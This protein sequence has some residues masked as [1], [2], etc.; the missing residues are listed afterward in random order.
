MH[1][2]ERHPSIKYFVIPKSLKIL[3]RVV[4]LI[5]DVFC[6]FK[7]M[8]IKG[9]ELLR[10]RLPLQNL[11][12]VVL[13]TNFFQIRGTWRTHESLSPMENFS[14]INNTFAVEFRKEF[15]HF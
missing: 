5:C 15:K 10:M 7:L 4:I 12:D 11:T 13:S 9:S 2:A 8:Q 14:P 3:F 6:I 1:F